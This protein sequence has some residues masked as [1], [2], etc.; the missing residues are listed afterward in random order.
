MGLAFYIVFFGLSLLIFF[1]YLFQNRHNPSSIYTLIYL[2][3]S[4]STFGYLQI[5]L[6]K[7]A[8][9]ALLATKIA[10]LGGQFLP[11]ILLILLARFVNA[12]NQKYITIISLFLAF[13]YFA[14]TT[15]FIG[16]TNLYYKNVEFNTENGIAYLVKDYGKLYIFSKIYTIFFMLIMVGFLIYA[17]K[18][19]KR[20]SYKN[21]ILLS[22]VIIVTLGFSLISKAFS[23]SI[24][25]MPC[26]YFISGLILILLI[27]RINIYNLSLISKIHFEDEKY[28][29]FIGFDNKRNFLGATS[30]A[31]ELFSKLEDVN[32]DVVLPRSED[33]K[34]LNDLIDNYFGQVDSFRHIQKDNETYRISISNI[35]FNKK[36]YGFFL[37][38]T[39][40]TKQVE[41]IRLLNNYK[42]ELSNEVKLKTEH[43]QS[44][45]DK[46]VLGMADI[47]ES[48]D[49][50]TG[51]HVRRTSNV[52]E[53]FTNILK[54]NNVY[55]KSDEF[56][57]YVRRA[58]PLHDLGKVS[59]QY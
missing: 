55:N 49:E 32:I 29:G 8:E 22:I 20:V 52:V 2:I 57:E 39:N 37:E 12:K 36:V 47:I 17:I 40:D 31:F 48:R 6:S 56:Y 14:I 35:V 1:I 4:I 50:S 54:N 9:E 53:I 42:E 44:I 16:N 51:G 23:K 43:I 11:S 5:A 24:D 19:I 38:I 7:N 41:Y 45:Q 18:H 13:L 59:K 33:F 21:L 10:Y 58:A 15:I 28:H 3:L 34:V 30:L 25:L 46:L 27:R 26:A